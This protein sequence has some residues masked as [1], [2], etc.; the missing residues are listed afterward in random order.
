MI[1]DTGRHG[2]NSGNVYAQG[3]R[4]EVELFEG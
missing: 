4:Y 2:E 1:R 3:C